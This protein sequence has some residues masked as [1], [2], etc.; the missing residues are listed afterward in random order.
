MEEK[1][2]YFKGGGK[3]HTDAALKIAKEYA[4]KHKI[5]SVVVAST[6]GFTASK[7]AQVFKGKN[8]IIVTHVHGM[9]NP[10]T[11]EFPQELRE[12]LESEGVKVITATHAMG[13]V[14][15]LAERSIGNIIADTLRMFCQGMKV[16]VEIA[17][18]AADA[19]LVRT[20]EE[21]I[22][23]AGTGRGADTVL[24]IQPEN[25]MRLF[26]MDVKKI[27]AMPI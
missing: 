22:S 4:D 9:R 5:K 3:Q 2:T 13:G 25:S 27:L 21:I 23:V 12:K 19:G 15:Y 1:I 26:D 24:V 20:D 6:T 16:A 11:I 18:E 14:N 10:D 17:A 8:L 7:A